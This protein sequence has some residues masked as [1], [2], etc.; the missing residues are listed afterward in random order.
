MTRNLACIK[1]ELE[2]AVA[3]IPGAPANPLEAYYRYEETAASLND[4]LAYHEFVTPDEVQ[5]LELYLLK[6]CELKALELDVVLD[7]EG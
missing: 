4:A 3:R 5:I 1:D 7:F 2:A 6:L